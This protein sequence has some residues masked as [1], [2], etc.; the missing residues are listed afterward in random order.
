MWVIPHYLG[1]FGAQRKL[2]LYLDSKWGAIMKEKKK[3]FLN[4]DFKEVFGNVPIGTAL[5]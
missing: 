1:Q 3:D 5:L 2:G 4:F